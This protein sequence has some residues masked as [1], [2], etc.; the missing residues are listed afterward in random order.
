MNEPPRHKTTVLTCDQCGRTYSNLYA[1][2]EE[3]Q[4]KTVRPVELTDT[5]QPGHISLPNGLGLAYPDAEGDEVL[6][7]VAPNELT[8]SAEYAL[9]SPEVNR[10]MM[11][12]QRP[13]KADERPLVGHVAIDNLFGGRQH[14]FA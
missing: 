13:V 14:R 5:L 9:I 11:I 12:V 2:I 10:A 4:G 1:H 7:G 8:A 6:T 3:C